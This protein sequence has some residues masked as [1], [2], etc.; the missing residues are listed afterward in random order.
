MKSSRET[1]L[2]NHLDS[3]GSQDEI[4]ID[5]RSPFGNPYGKREFN[6]TRSESI[7]LFRKYFHSNPELKA[8]AKEKLA[9]KTLVCWCKPKPCHGDVYIQFLNESSL[10]DFW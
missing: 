9:G 3:T 4:W 2:I 7:E 1:T 5:R 6:I 10:E 8:L